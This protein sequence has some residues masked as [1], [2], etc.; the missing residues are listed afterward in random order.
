MNEPRS[1]S[2]QD[3]GW[4]LCRYE[5]SMRSLWDDMADRSNQGTFLFRRNY[6]DYEAGRLDDASLL[7]YR[8]GH[9]EALFPANI[10][11]RTLISHGGLTYGGL[12][13]TGSVGTESMLHLF[14]ALNTF[15]RE[16]W[17]IERVVYRPIPYIYSRY[18]ADEDLYALWRMG[19]HITERKVS[20]ALPL[21]TPQP[22]AQLRRRGLHKAAA[23]AL[24]VIND[25]RYDLFWPLL[26]KVLSERHYTRPVHSLDE[27]MLLHQRFPAEIKLF[28]VCGENGGTIGGTVLYISRQVVH[29]QYIA[30]N[31]EG[32]QKGALD[33]LFHHL[34]HNVK[35]AAR[36]F[37]FGNSV[38]EGGH[39]LNTG[40]IAQKEGFGARAVMYDTYEW[41]TST[42]IH[43][44]IP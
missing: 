16:Q 23:N 6:M 2:G 35:W 19:A 39:R 22:F 28:R 26:E 11:E 8:K 44:K 1:A 9:L 17:G 5:K 37:D 10:R 33:L 18:P 43:D 24:C 32:R 12:L 13:T 15:V 31:D 3:T 20:S 4:T 42:N 25:E 34:I 7:C 41:N 29:A 36:W 14:S 40:L 30:A 38:E 21:E 27:I